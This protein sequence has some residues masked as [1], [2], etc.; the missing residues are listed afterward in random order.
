[1]AKKRTFEE[2]LNAE[3]R[4]PTKGDAPFIVAGD[5]YDNALIEDNTAAR[6]ILMMEG[7][8]AAAD[9]MVR[10]SAHDR[11]ER[12]KLV[13]PVLFNYRQFLELAL[14]Y[15][16]ATYGPFVKLEPDWTTHDLAVLWKKFLEMLDRYGTDDA[17]KA[18]TIV[19]Q[20]ILE[21][22]KIDP[23]SYSHRYP[24]DRNGRPIP[25]SCSALHLPNLAEVMD[26]V[27]G[28]FTGCDGYLSDLRQST[29]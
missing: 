2:M 10:A 4:W 27:E 28:Y 7:Y 19:G 6:L 18:D 25:V 11:T 14:K 16:L 17:D 20:I 9:L 3:L 29:P 15:H 13:F 8:K 26:G 5:P 24:V 23:K 12:D 1:M 21:F 22:A